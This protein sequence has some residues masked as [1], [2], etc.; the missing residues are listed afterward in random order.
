[1]EL[2]TTLTAWHWFALGLVLMIL[3]LFVGSFFLL[4]IGITALVMGCIRWFIPDLS[5]EAQA[6]IFAVGAVG[7]VLITRKY[8]KI[9]VT[10]QKTGELALN[11]RAEQYVGREFTL[12]TPMVNGRGKIRAGDTSWIIEGEDMPA[13][14]VVQVV[15]TSGVI[16]KV[17]RM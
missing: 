15:G 4:W 12:E 8:A 6:I 3:E 1:M 13:G 10:Q 16:L 9:S 2:F 11:R 7:A 5:G 17:K 14:A